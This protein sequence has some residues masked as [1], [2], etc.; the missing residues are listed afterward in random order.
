[1]GYKGKYDLK[2]VDAVKSAT[3]KTLVSKLFLDKESMDLKITCSDKTFMCHKNVLSCQSE[4]FKAM[5]VNMKTKE[6]QSGEIK[7]GDFT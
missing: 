4:V 1:M 3:Q 6:A 7:I 5:F 2:I